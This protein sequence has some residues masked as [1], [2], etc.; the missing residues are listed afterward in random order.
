MDAVWKDAFVT[1]ASLLEAIRVLRERSATTACNPTY[2]Q[3]VHRRGYRFVAPITSGS[4]PQ[5]AR[6]RRSR[7]GAPIALDAARIGAPR[8]RLRHEWRPLLV[9]GAAAAIA[10]SASRIVFARVRPAAAGATADD[11]LHDRAA[12]R[13]GHRSAARIGRRVGRRH[14]HGLRRAARGPSA[15]V[16]AH[17]RSRRAAVIDGSDGAA[18]P[19]FSPDGQWVGFF[20]HGSLKK[21]RVEGGTPVAAV[22]GPR[23]RRRELEPRRHHR[24]RRRARRRP[25]ARLGGGGEPVVLTAPPAGS[26][27]V[28]YGWPDVLPGRLAVLYTAV[29][30]AGSRVALF[31]VAQR[32]T[33]IRS[34]SSGAFGRYSPTGHLVFERRGRLEAAPFSLTRAAV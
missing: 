3:T 6:R 25:R 17:H 15:P 34:S 23:R 14:A 27:E 5:P 9:A 24:V 4:D 11:A 7:A 16:P 21:L 32:R 29:S 22:R 2:I 12:G 19:F 18:D 8:R 26:R 1:E 31:D 20:A 28:S 30:L 10:W 33:V 13:H